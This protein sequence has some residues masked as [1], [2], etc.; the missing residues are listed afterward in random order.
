M[1]SYKNVENLEKRLMRME[2]LLQ[3]QECGQLSE[4][5]SNVEAGN[6]T[7][8]SRKRKSPHQST[9]Q[10]NLQNAGKRA[11]RT[12]REALV[13]SLSSSPLEMEDSSVHVHGLYPSGELEFDY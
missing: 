1:L 3:S 8:S 6:Q 9:A 11:R 12:S 7:R 13:H 10:S 2:A 4:E 5:M